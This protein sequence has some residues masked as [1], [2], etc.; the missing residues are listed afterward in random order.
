MVMGDDS[1]VKGHEFES[2]HRL[3]DGHLFTLICIVCLKRPKINEIEAGIGPFFK[4]TSIIG[5]GTRVA[6]MISP[7]EGVVYPISSV[8]F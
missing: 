7:F 5:D 3:L 8:D 2:R 1:C 6:P 4:I